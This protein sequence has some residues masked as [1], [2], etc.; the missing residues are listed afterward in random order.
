MSHMGQVYFVYLTEALCKLLDFHD[1]SRSFRGAL[2]S[3]NLEIDAWKKNGWKT[4]KKLS[5]R[6]GC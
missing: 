1:W 3:S 2:A 5:G 4:Q 6:L